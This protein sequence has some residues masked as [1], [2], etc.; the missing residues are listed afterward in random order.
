MHF[1]SRFTQFRQGEV[2]R[3]KHNAAHLDQDTSTR[4]L[5]GRHYP[6]HFF[7]RR[8]HSSQEAQ[9]D[10]RGMGIG[11]CVGNVRADERKRAA[12]GAQASVDGSKLRIRIGLENFAFT[13][14][15][16]RPL[17]LLQR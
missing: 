1:T 13:G 2:L 12:P 4:G 8:R 11:A 16:A 7:F 9:C 5:V 3:R 15:I 17:V 14:V 6:S 10:L